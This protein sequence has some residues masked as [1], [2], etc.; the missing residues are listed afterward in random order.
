MPLRRSDAAID[1]ADHV[2]L[3]LEAFDGCD[4]IAVSQNH[5]TEFLEIEY[6]FQRLM[7]DVTSAMPERLG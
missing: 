6:A 7:T 1:G 2:L 5:S 4:V 3:A